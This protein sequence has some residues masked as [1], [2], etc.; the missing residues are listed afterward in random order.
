MITLLIG[1]EGTGKTKEMIDLANARA[2]V[3]DGHVVFLSKTERLKLDL[4]HD[5][6]VVSLK[7]YPEI[8]NSDEYIGFLYGIISSDYDIESI[9]VD[10]VLKQSHVNKE[11]IPQFLQ[12]LKVISEEHD[13]RFT[14]SLDG[15]IDKLSEKYKDFQ[16]IEATGCGC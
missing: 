14:V 2:K 7:D 11:D 16:I 4:V 12:R 8:T 10:S 6:R 13:I 1:G 5:I 15:D 3:S 9:Y